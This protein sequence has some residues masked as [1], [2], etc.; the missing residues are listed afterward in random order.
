ME[1]GHS[2]RAITGI[3][4]LAFDLETRLERLRDRIEAIRTSREDTPD[5][6]RGF[7]WD[8]AS[9]LAAFKSVQVVLENS[10]IGLRQFEGAL[11][12]LPVCA[13]RFQPRN[14]GFLL[15][16]KITRVQDVLCSDQGLLEFYRHHWIDSEFAGT[17]RAARLPPHLWGRRVVV[18]APKLAS[19]RAERGTSL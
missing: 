14:S 16:D 1:G 6:R 11:G 10:K 2:P 15:I 18:G 5:L 3:E 8:S 9:R 13:S 7:C 17:A 19:E 4:K 12:I